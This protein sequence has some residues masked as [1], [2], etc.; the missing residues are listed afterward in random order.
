MRKGQALKRKRFTEEQII[1]VL[2]E[3]ELCVQLV[4]SAS[5]KG[6][7]DRDEPG[8]GRLAALAV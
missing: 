2:K 3:H 8:V 7:A 4:A 1:G 6:L 5:W